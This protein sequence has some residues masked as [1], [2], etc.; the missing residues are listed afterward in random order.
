MST[1]FSLAVDQDTGFNDSDQYIFSDSNF[2]LESDS[3]PHE[4]C[5]RCRELQKCTAINYQ[6]CLPVRIF[7]GHTD[8]GPQSRFPDFM[9]WC[10]DFVRCGNF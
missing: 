6:A 10:T 5:I 2:V 4:E 9:R 1:L 7:A 3:M 8:F